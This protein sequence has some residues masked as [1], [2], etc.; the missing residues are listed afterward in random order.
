MT[1]EKQPEY[2]HNA[3]SYK[4]IDSRED[5]LKNIKTDRGNFRIKENGN[6]PK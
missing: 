5:R 1:K 2:D 6:T 3:H 4:G